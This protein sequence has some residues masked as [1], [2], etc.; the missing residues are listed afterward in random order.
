M[1]QEIRV[2]AAIGFLQEKRAPFPAYEISHPEVDA[3]QLRL[4]VKPARALELLLAVE[5]TD[6]PIKVLAELEMPK[7]AVIVVVRRVGLP[8][9]LECELIAH[10]NA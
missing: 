6:A 2:K 4:H 10:R 7:A 3:P 9:K 5:V 8:V 1:A